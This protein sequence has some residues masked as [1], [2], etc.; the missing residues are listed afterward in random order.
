MSKYNKELINIK[1]SP[2][3]VVLFTKNVTKT[4]HLDKSTV[5]RLDRECMRGICV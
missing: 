5:K 4:S 3:I 2:F 1:N